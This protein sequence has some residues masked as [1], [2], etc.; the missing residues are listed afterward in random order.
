MSD[1]KDYRYFLI[2]KKQKILFK[3][4]D[5]IN[6]SSLIK[7]TSIENTSINHIFYLFL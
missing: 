3:T 4:Y 2:I 5:P 1:K 7:E 6:G